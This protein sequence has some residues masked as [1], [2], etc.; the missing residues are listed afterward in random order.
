MFGPSGS[1]GFA[2]S[3]SMDVKETGEEIVIDPDLEEKD[4]S[5]SVQNGVLTIE[6]EKKLDYDEEKQNY[7]VMEAALR[8]LK[9]SLRLPDT[10]DDT[11]IDARFD[12]GVL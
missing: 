12:N 6:G 4:I 3:F 7:H 11:K 1:Q 8:Q 9:R 2:L 5:L 10:I